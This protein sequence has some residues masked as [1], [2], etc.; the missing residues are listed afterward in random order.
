M[1]RITHLDLGLWI[2]LYT[3]LLP[4]KSESW[5]PVIQNQSLS[6]IVL[7]GN[8]VNFA[9]ILFKFGTFDLSACAFIGPSVRG[10]NT[11]LVFV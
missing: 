11:I 6:S 2:K 7:S 1:R 3:L 4:V 10:R 5:L 8:G 9:V